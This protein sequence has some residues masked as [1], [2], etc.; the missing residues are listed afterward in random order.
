LNQCLMLKDSGDYPEEAR[1]KIITKKLF[2]LY[3][4]IKQES[5]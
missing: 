4:T 1:D 2:D 5:E 3:Y